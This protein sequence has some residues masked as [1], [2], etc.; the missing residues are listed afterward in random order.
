MLTPRAALLIGA[1]FLSPPALAQDAPQQVTPPPIAT[2]P[3]PAPAPA[4]TAP[5][6][7]M[8]PSTPVVQSVPSVAEQQAGAA[9]ADAPAPAERRATS[10]A[11][12]TRTTTT[13][14]RAA[15]RAPAPAAR[16]SAP[17]PAPAAQAPAPAEQAPALAPAAPPVTPAEPPAASAPAPES[18][19]PPT[20]TDTTTEQTRAPGF[21]WPWLIGGALLVL[22]G[23]AV[24]LF[25]RRRR[26]DEPVFVDEAYRAPVTP[27]PV[28]EPVAAPDAAVLAEEPALAPYLRPAPAPEI[29]A[30]AEVEAGI[31]KADD[32]DLAGIVEAP[33]PVSQRPWI[34]LGMRPVRAGTSEEEAIVDFELTVGNSGDTPA[35]DVRISSFMLPEPEGSE[36]EQL[37]MEHRDETIVPP[38]TIP[39]G[40]G[41]RVDA[42]L[43]VPKGELGR[44]FNPVVVAEARYTLPDGSE[45]RTAAAF[46]IGRPAGEGGIGA[47]GSSRPHLVEDLAAELY[48]EPAHA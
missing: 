26:A 32:A 25:S 8:Q 33:A 30:E 48:G 15:E 2:T 22:A 19:A 13:R 6:I 27:E 28:A 21:A 46:R 16:A 39:A 35:R 43:A 44:T 5:R 45:A 7:E 4:Q 1:A 20:V 23:L 14:T 11:R 29:V 41:T 10:T 47:I 37:L 38:V 24:I 31:A 12:T 18:A 9:A 3:A 34:E 17:A 36:M 40:D 42:H